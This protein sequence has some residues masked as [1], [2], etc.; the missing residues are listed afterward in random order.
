[1]T[2][3]DCKTHGAMIRDSNFT[4]STFLLQFYVKIF[5]YWDNSMKTSV[6]IKTRRTAD[7]G[8]PPVISNPYSN[9]ELSLDENDTDADESDQDERSPPKTVM[10]KE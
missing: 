4:H 5:L 9:S 10:R 3:E 8:F 2:R 7:G 6:F 1:M